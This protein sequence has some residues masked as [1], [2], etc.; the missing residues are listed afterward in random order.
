MAYCKN[1][2]NQIDDGSKFC[3]FCGAN[4]ESNEQH[5]YS[6]PEQETVEQNPAEQQYTGAFYTEPLVPKA[7][8]AL[9]VGM[10]VWSIINL[11]MCCMPLGIVSLIMTVMAQNATSAQDEIDKLKTAKICNLIGTIAVGIFVVIYIV[12]VGLAVVVGVSAA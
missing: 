6:A 11:V 10:L 9:K 3:S 1:C 5:Q 2:G 8:G 4:Q 7:S 12:L